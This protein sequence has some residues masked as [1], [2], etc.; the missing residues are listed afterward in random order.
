MDKKRR[1]KG[2]RTYVRTSRIVDDVITA[3]DA[4]M[5]SNSAAQKT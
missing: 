5:T 4:T 2:I 1:Q 3:D